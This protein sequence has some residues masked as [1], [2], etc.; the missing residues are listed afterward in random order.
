MSEEYFKNKFRTSTTRLGYWDYSWAARYYI[1]IC[2]K[3]RRC[4]LSEIKDSQVYLSEMGTVVSD[5]LLKIPELR[6]YVILDDYI[7][8]PNHIHVIF[9]LIADNDFGHS[10]GRDAVN[11]VSTVRKFGPLQ[12]KSLSAIINTFKGGVTRHCHE[13]G[14]NCQWQS[15]YYEHIIRDEDDYARIKE[16]IFCNPGK[17]TEDRNNSNNIK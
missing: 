6:S 11:R 5:D 8:M 4:C 14:L 10:D 17:W 13:K 3:D 7:I 1:T 16:Y 15:N 2:T 9:I 12:P